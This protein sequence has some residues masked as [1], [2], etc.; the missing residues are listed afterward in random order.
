MGAL[1]E[2]A[3]AGRERAAEALDAV[4]RRVPTPLAATVRRILDRDILLQASSLAFYGLV[5]AL[6]LLII[7]FAVVGAFT[8]EGT[9]EQFSRSVSETG[10]SGTGEIVDRLIS[11]S[12]TMPWLTLVFIIWPATAYGGG[13]RR[14]LQHAAGRDSQLAGLRGRVMG[15]G[16]VLALPVFV[17]GGIP[18]MFVLAS[19]SGD[20]AAATALGWGLAVASG[21]LVGTVVTSLLYQTFA[22]ADLGW[23][24]SIRGAAL[25]AVATALFSL[26]FVIYLEVGNVSDRFGGGT[27]G[28][29]VLLG[30]WLF[31]ANILLLAG[32]HAVLAVERDGA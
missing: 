20:G 19:L 31:V 9:L 27:I 8:A 30:V 4:D 2:A 14:A 1:G 13:L 3:E 16:F 24:E 7:A 15:L 21:A 22:P 29:V 18:L 12:D 11:S 23:R 28:L 5:S 25:S 10:P 26:G 32:Y 17:L 6:P